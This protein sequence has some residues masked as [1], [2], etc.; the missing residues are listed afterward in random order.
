MGPDGD[1]DCAESCD[2]AAGDCT[3][4][5]PAGANCDDGNACTENDICTGGVCGGDAIICDDGIGCTDDGCDTLKGCQ[6]IPNDANCNDGVGCTDDTCDALNDCQF[7][8]IDANCDDGVGCTDDTCDALNDCQ[9]MPNDAACDD[10]DACTTDTCDPGVGCVHPPIEPCCGNG[11]VESG[12]QCDPPDGLICDDTCQLFPTG[13][14]CF[15]TGTC[16][17]GLTSGQCTAPGA[18]YQGDASTCIPD[19]CPECVPNPGAAQNDCCADAIAIFSGLTDFD[20]NN[21]DTDGPAH[22]DECTLFSDGGQTFHDIWYTYMA[23]CSADTT[24]TTC[25]DLGG[26]A[27]YDTDLVVY[28]GCDCDNLVLLG[29]N[30]DDPNNTCGDQPLYQSTV[31]VP[32]VGG[33]CYLIRVGGWNT[34]DMGTGTVLIEPQCGAS[35]PEDLNGDGTVGPFDLALIL[36]F[37][38]PCPEPCKPGPPETTCLTDLNGDCETGPFDLAVILGFW[39]PCP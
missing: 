19:M 22:P 33:N 14:C 18:T 6:F 12:E 20:T 7:T 24:V 5:D 29:C 17:D 9:F 1:A 36:G 23:E 13:A 4:P 8:P 28:N 27:D 35:C 26:T 15:L 16:Q 11:V 2:E 39:G 21:A 38:G 25:E 3:A 32:M 31:T 37:W 10:G 34:G 30:D